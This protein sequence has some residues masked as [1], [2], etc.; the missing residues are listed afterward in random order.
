MF[1][2][3]VGEDKAFGWLPF[4]Q[5]LKRYLL[6]ILTFSCFK[7][8]PNIYVNFAAKAPLLAYNSFIEAI[9]VLND[10]TGHGA[11]SE[12]QRSSDRRPA[13]FAIRWDK[14][15]CTCRNNASSLAEFSHAHFLL[16][17][18]WWKIEVKTNAHLC[19]FAETN[20]TRAPISHLSQIMCWD[21][22]SCLWWLTQCW[23]CWW[24]G[25]T[26]GWDH[27]ISCQYEV[28]MNWENIAESKYLIIFFEKIKYLDAI[29]DMMRTAYGMLGTW[30]TCNMHMHPGF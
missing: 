19:F 2:W 4:W 16:Q 21:L 20:G 1:S 12:S 26:S 15:N 27:M 7:S 13:L 9:Y 29:F 8:L 18:H 30:P 6:F 17:W 11:H 14:L 5:H 10:C 23:W 28:M 24:K 25:C 3:W 22:G